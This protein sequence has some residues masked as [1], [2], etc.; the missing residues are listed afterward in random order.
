MVHLGG[1]GSSPVS[2]GW[3]WVIG[4][5]RQGEGSRVSASW[6]I[7]LL[8][9]L[10]FQVGF[11]LLPRNP[12]PASPPS[13]RLRQKLSIIQEASIRYCALRMF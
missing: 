3:P 6:W 5:A 1:D 13:P 12:Q 10:T 8:K 4:M 7:I 11:Y 2:W 9:C